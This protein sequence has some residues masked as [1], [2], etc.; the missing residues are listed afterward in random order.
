MAEIAIPLATAPRGTE[1][2]ALRGW[3]RTLTAAAPTPDPSGTPCCFGRMGARDAMV[4]RGL[5]AAL[6]AEHRGAGR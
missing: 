1:R 3:L 5:A 4:A 2:V 6:A